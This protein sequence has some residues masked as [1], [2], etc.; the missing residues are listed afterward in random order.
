MPLAEGQVQLRGLVLGPGTPYRLAEHFN[1]WTLTVRAEQGGARPWAHGAW[2]GAEWR[3]EIP[4]VIRLTTLGAG[5]AGWLALHQPLA[6][7]W[8]PSD[9]DLEL[10]FVV[11]G[12]EFVMFG[13]PRML[14]PS[15]R[16][17]DGHGRYEL[18]F[19][20]LDPTVYSGVEHVAGP[21]ELPTQAGGLALPFTLPYTVAG[22]LVGGTAE[23]VNA[24]TKPAPLRVRIDAPVPRPGFVL[25]RPDSTLQ[26]VEVDLD[27]AAGQWLDI[28]T[29]AG[30]VLLNGLVTA[31]QRGVT[32]WDVDPEPLLPGTTTFRFTG[33][34]FD[35]GVATPRW[36]DAWW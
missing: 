21:V 7:A 35:A 19:S 17:V 28:D 15:P 25:Q 1:P 16:H 18:G 23:L 31:S 8:A 34:D 5:G 24:G 29:A 33:A 32:A 3:E 22:Q 11:G 6:A 13:R 27:L 12:Q 10:R 14:T 2:S 4:I 9:L 20:C 30:T 26:R 36:R